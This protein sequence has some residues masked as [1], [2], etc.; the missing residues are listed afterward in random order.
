MAY[1]CVKQDGRWRSELAMDWGRWIRESDKLYGKHLRLR[2]YSPFEY[3]EVAAVGFLTAA[4]ARA[5]F[6]TLNE[7]ETTKSRKTGSR[8]RPSH[9]PGRA[10]LWMLG[11]KYSYSFEFKRAWYAA[12][13]KNLKK[14]MKAAV[15]D[16]DCSHEEC[17]YAVGGLIA[18]VEHEKRNK[19]CMEFVDDPEV[20]FAYRIGPR[21]RRGA[22]LYFSIRS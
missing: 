6:L 9:V 7:F 2:D 21:G 15:S 16:I 13:L 3:H 4:A 12:T 5:G 17:K 20:N 19:A 14:Q 18:F 22:F 8:G 11:K 1:E 10:D